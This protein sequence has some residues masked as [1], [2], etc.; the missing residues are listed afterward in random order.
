MAKRAAAKGYKWADLSITGEDNEDTYPL[1][2]HMGAKIY[3]RYR[4]YRKQ[5]D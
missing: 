5:I 4:I 1:A 3:K 2:T